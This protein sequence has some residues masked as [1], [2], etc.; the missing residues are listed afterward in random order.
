MKNIFLVLIL[1]LFSYINYAQD[2]PFILEDYAI[3]VRA[4]KSDHNKVLC[5]DTTNSKRIGFVAEF[6]VIND[7]DIKRFGNRIYAM[8]I[9]CNYHGDGVFDPDQ[10]WDLKISEQKY[11]LKEIKI[12]NEELLYKNVGSKKYWIRDLSRKYILHEPLVKKDR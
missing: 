6:E 9:C 10:I 5:T 3:K 2:K 1:S 7:A 12:V 11:Y 4:I 8:D